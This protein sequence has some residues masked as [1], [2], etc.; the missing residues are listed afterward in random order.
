MREF[1]R[2]ACVLT[3][4]KVILPR[5]QIEQEEAS[6]WVYEA[7][8]RAESN[9]NGINSA[10]Q[11]RTLRSKKNFDHY[12][13]KSHQVKTR[14]VDLPDVTG[15]DWEKNEIYLLHP[16][17][18]R[19]GE[20]YQGKSI[21]DRTNFFARRAF[22]AFRGFYPSSENPPQ[23]LIHVTCTG[24]HSPSAA[25]RIVAEHHW[26]DCPQVTHAY[27]M[28]C[29]AALSSIRIAQGLLEVSR[30]RGG[31]HPHPLPR[32]DLVHTELCSLHMNPISHE[33]EQIVIQS[34]FAD[35]YIKYSA[36]PLENARRGFVIL[37][38]AEQ[39][40]PDTEGEMTWITE[41]WGMGMSL[42]RNVP[43]TIAFYLP[44]FLKDLLE[45]AEISFYQALR[46]GVFA[47]HPGGP[48]IIDEI[49]SLLDLQDSQVQASRDVLLNR[50]NMSSATLPHIWAQLLEQVPPGTKIVSLAFGPGLS[51]LG[52][53]FQT[54]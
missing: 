26:I 39:I 54:I 13:A 4:F 20:F 38:H 10:Q 19:H 49:Q 8:T 1:K 29:Y 31:D 27:H 6:R 45:K 21:G 47:I 34:I 15:R 22:E 24:Y 14:R 25:Q 28:G 32:I 42:S 43:R 48:K 11:I 44:T 41:P 46:E 9:K 12:F 23:H 35:G 53:V 30:V 36:I 5:F 52:S 37:E 16:D 3:D 40:L 7:H 18:A 17:H 51:I 50:G 2:N 33:P